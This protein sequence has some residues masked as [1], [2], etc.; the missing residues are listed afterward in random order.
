MAT[1]AAFMSGFNRKSQN[2]DSSQG[3]GASDAFQAGFSKGQSRSKAAKAK[4]TLKQA[5]SPLSSG[6][7]AMIPLQSVQGFPVKS[8][9]RGGHVKRTGLALLHRGEHVIPAGKS[10]TKNPKTK[11]V[12]SLVRK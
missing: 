12:A 9:K 8:F 4:N 6:T 10:K 11:I 1:N 5:Q 3:G 7:T 2:D